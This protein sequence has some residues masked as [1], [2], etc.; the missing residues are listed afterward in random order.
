MLELLQ[1]CLHTSPV[2]KLHSNLCSYK[3]LQALLEETS[4]GAFLCVVGKINTPLMPFLEI[5]VII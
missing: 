4:R 1:T 5:N 2:R 3:K